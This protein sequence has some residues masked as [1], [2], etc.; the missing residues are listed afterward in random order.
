M[1]GSI[2]IGNITISRGVTGST[3]EALDSKPVV[4]EFPRALS[5]DAFWELGRFASKLSEDDKFNKRY[6]E[7]GCS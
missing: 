7:V 6:G 2:E 5:D 3:Q 4:I 1:I